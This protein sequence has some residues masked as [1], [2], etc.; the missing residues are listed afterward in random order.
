MNTGDTIFKNTDLELHLVAGITR[1]INI[2]SSV[3]ENF[4]AEYLTSDRL[5]K[6]YLQIVSYHEEN[7]LILNL[8]SYIK[9]YEEDEAEKMLTTNMWAKINAEKPHTTLESVIAAKITLQN[10]YVYRQ[11]QESTKQLIRQLKVASETKNYNTE[12]I[13]KLVRGLECETDARGLSEIVELHQGYD[14]FIDDYKKAVK[15]PN[16][17]RGIPTGIDQID[18][19]M[20]GLRNSELGMIAGNSGSGKSIMLMNYAMNCWAHYGDVIVITIEMSKLDYIERMYCYLSQIPSERFRK[21]LLNSKELQY[22]QRVDEKVQAHPHKM[23]IVDMKG[24]CTVSSINKQIDKLMQQNPGKIKMIAIDYMNI[25]SDSTGETNLQWESQVQTAIKLKLMVAR[26]FNVPVWSAVQTT[27][28]NDGIAF[29][30]HLVDQ[31][32]VG[33]FITPDKDTEITGILPGKFFKT[34]GFKASKFQLETNYAIWSCKPGN[35]QL[36][37]KLQT[38]RGNND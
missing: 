10:L 2:L 17:L 24:Q 34:R 38:M 6:I 27:I 9:L 25:I 3:C 37:R 12:P 33:I 22:I 5:R 11:T 23:H 28:D 20:V 1:G 8:D 14:L 36:A 4:D 32:D 35:S 16:Q 29:S 15:N 21:H 30:S 18:R 13:V 26:A 7:G 19:Y 31:L